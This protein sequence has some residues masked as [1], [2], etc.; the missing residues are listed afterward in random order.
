MKN[1]VYSVTILSMGKI[2]ES[3]KS[4]KQKQKLFS[5]AGM[6]AV[7]TAQNNNLPIT[8]ASGNKVIKEY[9][10]GTTEVLALITPVQTTVPKKF[11]IK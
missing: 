1:T 5:Q 11:I 8:Y 10:D 9:P 6:I 4:Q 7:K 2:T 3:S